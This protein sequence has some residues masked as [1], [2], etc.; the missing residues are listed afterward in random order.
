MLKFLLNEYN[1]G[2]DGSRGSVRVHGHPKL[3]DKAISMLI[4][5]LIY[6]ALVTESSFLLEV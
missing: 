4:I 5:P 6:V 3:Q 1:T 2:S